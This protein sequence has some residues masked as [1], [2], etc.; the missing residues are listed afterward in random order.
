[1]AILKFVDRVS[2]SNKPVESC[3]GILHRIKKCAVK[4]QSFFTRQTRMAGC[5]PSWNRYLLRFAEPKEL[6]SYCL[7]IT[8]RTMRSIFVETDPDLQ[9]RR[10]KE[11]TLVCLYLVRRSFLTLWLILFYYHYSWFF[12]LMLE[13]EEDEWK[14]YWKILADSLKLKFDFY[15]MTPKFQSW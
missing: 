5:H 8:R 13:K 11:I 10:C 6:S 9:S 7:D 2:R 14:I 12:Y 15:R 3:R 4:L 1:M